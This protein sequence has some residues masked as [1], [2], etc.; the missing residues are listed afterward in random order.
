VH[1][2]RE[3]TA[4]CEQRALE[5][6]NV[7]SQ[8]N[9]LVSSNLRTELSAA[10]LR[11][12]DEAFNR[13]ESAMRRRIELIR[14]THERLSALAIVYNS[15]V[16]RSIG[17]DPTGLIADVL[18]QTWDWIGQTH[19]LL[20]ERVLRSRA[21]LQRCRSFASNAE[22][23]LLQMSS[24][25]ARS[26]NECLF[27]SLSSILVA[28]NINQ[29]AADETL[30]ICAML[31]ERC[32]QRLELIYRIPAEGTTLAALLDRFERTLGSPKIALFECDQSLHAIFL[33]HRS[34]IGALRST[35]NRIDACLGVS[36]T[37]ASMA[38]HQIAQIGVSAD[39]FAN[40][41]AENW[42]YHR[43]WLSEMRNQISPSKQLG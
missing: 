5:F 31:Q 19:T 2:L 29:R 21:L 36:D 27:T 6:D 22:A 40:R 34:L 35:S 28:I 38:A 43:Q 16:F 1:L 37:M 14:F 10:R 32:S 41:I 26:G 39:K 11:E 33:R 23:A 18:Q 3:C 9:L 12:L 4:E 17:I 24:G 13:I 8:L 25:F 42:V 30:E 20:S 15:G 7:A